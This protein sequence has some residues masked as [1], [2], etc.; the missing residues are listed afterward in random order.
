ME[1]K[2]ISIEVAESVPPSA[3]GITGKASSRK[4]RARACEGI[5][6][7]RARRSSFSMKETPLFLKNLGIWVDRI[8][9][10][11]WTRR[12]WRRRQRPCTRPMTI[13]SSSPSASSSSTRRSSAPRHGESGIL[14]NYLR[15]ATRLFPCLPA[16]NDTMTHAHQETIPASGALVEGP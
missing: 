10:S 12:N 1:L 5:L 4:G 11:A 15:V 16:H 6:I 13:S 3:R 9:V 14:L 7:V 2:V 8:S